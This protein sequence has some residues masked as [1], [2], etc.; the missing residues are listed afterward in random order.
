MLAVLLAGAGAAGIAQRQGEE[1]MA[2]RQE[3][4]LQRAQSGVKIQIEQAKSVLRGVRGAFAAAPDLD[5][6]R[7]ARLA[8]PSLGRS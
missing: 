7:F 4:W 1:K 8:N 2:E 5:Q 6:E 3:A